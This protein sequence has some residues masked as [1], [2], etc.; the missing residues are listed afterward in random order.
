MIS[1]LL[2]DSAVFGASC[3]VAMDVWPTDALS[4]SV[5]SVFH[6]Q[7]QESQTAS[8]IVEDTVFTLWLLA[9]RESGCFDPFGLRKIGWLLQFALGIEMCLECQDA[10][11]LGSPEPAYASGKS[12]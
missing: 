2:P 12:L 9:S 8:A 10:V 7:A 11:I 5:L 4:R 1:F 3:R 6:D